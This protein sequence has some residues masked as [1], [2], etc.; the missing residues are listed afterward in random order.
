MSLNRWNFS[1]GQNEIAYVTR[2]PTATYDLAQDRKLTE[3]SGWKIAYPSSSDE[4]SSKWT[5]S[6]M[7]CS[8]ENDA[9]YS[10]EKMDESCED[11]DVQS[12][13]REHYN[14]SHFE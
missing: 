6:K 2:K 13:F 4:N 9:C 1:V 8:Y 10:Q 7:Q 5:A 12:E 11:C 3:N 14:V